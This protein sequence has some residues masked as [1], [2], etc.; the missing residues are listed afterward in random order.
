M[1]DQQQV[2]SMQVGTDINLG[3]YTMG[4]IVD[5]K[6][7][8]A[9]T[10]PQWIQEFALPIAQED[11]QPLLDIYAEVMNIRNDVRE[12]AVQAALIQGTLARISAQLTPWYVRAYRYLHQSTVSL[13]SFISRYF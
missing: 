13:T 12:L 3:G 7:Y 5:P 1:M 6:D 8:P 11:R 9:V 2:M 4:A 10:L